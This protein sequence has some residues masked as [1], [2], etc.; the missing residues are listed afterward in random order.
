MVYALGL[1]PAR[2]WLDFALK[3][4]IILEYL[5]VRLKRIT[6]SNKHMSVYYNRGVDNIMKIG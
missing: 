1:W 3:L 4:E 6:V 2:C 5:P